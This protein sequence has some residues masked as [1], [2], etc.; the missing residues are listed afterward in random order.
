MLNVIYAECCKFAQ[1]AE[2]L[3]ADCH[4]ANLLLGHENSTKE[5]IQRCIETK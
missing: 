1:Y 4:G 3:C 2:C 5:Y